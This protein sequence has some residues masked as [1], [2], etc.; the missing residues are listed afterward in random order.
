MICNNCKKEINDNAKFCPECGSRLNNNPLSNIDE[1]TNEMK[2]KKKRNKGFQVYHLL[3]GS[4]GIF[5]VFI[6]LF[7]LGIF[8]AI[9]DEFEYRIYEREQ[10]V[11]TKQKEEQDRQSAINYIKE[12]KELFE[13]TRFS[14]DSEIGLITDFYSDV[15]NGYHG[16]AHAVFKG[17]TDGKEGKSFASLFALTFKDYEKDL[18][19]VGYKIRSCE[20]LSVNEGF[21]LWKALEQYDHNP[22]E[23][24]KVLIRYNDVEVLILEVIFDETNKTVDW[25]GFYSS[26]IPKDINQVLN[27]SPAVIMAK[28]KFNISDEEF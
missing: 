2:E 22:G 25:E 27:E 15:L 5:L 10:K 18:R 9:K 19:T 14:F 24:Y 4:I 12:K 3:F 16:Y 1:E 13:N 20:K 23:Q 7:Q 28:E 21:L 6:I 17:R 11:I 26:I 8:E